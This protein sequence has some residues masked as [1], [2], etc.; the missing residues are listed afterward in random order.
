VTRTPDTDDDLPRADLDEVDP[1]R[2]RWIRG[3]LAVLG[4]MVL[5]AAL[6]LAA[7]AILIWLGVSP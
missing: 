1:R 3:A 6:G 7:I 2:D 5:G 4:V